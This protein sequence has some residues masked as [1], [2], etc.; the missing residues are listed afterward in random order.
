MHVIT[1]GEP[2]KYRPFHS[3]TDP[4][5]GLTSGSSARSHSNKKVIIFL[6]VSRLQGDNKLR[7][8]YNVPVLGMEAQ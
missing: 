5:K 8:N 2:I 7:V 6:S 1:G 4:T 3:R